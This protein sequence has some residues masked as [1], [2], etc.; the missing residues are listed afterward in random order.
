MK[1]RLLTILFIF[2]ITGVFI[3]IVFHLKWFDYLC[4]PLIMISIG[5]YFLQNSKKI[6]KRIIRIALI[7][8]LFSLF[9]D[10]FLMFTDKR[11]ILF[12]LGLGSFLV[13]QVSYSLL[14]HRS[15]KISD[16]KPFLPGNWIWLIGY[17]TYGV[18]F[19][20]SLFNHLDVILKIA[21]FAYMTALLGMSAMALNRFKA[22]NS[23]SFFQ[24]FT[25]SVLFVI[26]DSLI[27]LDKFL[28]PIPNNLL[29]V[30]STY[31]AAQYLIMRGILKQFV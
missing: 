29:L 6:D 27:A 25:G 5:S 21:A 12:I 14:F 24:V 26:S 3:G 28:M 9:G 17:V 4:K 2:S 15:V 1:N 18:I 23:S 22:V 7:A 13:A 10:I 31:I 19:Y 30:M 20:I 11:M 8:F 16:N